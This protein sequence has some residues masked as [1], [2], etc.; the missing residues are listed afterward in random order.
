MVTG[1]TFSLHGCQKVLGLFGGMGGHGH[2]R[3][4]TMPWWAG[5]IELVCGAL[6][7]FGLLTR[8]AAFIA[9]GEMAVAYFMVH[10]HRGPLPIQNGGELAVVYCFL[11]LYLFAAGAG[12]LSLDFAIRKRE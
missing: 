1:F 5:I 10:A 8:I 7:V 12:P 2:A 4:F 11:F 3:L 6:L 9:S